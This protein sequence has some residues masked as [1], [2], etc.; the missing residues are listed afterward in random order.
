MRL[1]ADRREWLEAVSRSGVFVLLTYLLFRTLAP[2]VA[3][4]SREIVT[5]NLL[6]MPRLTRNAPS[7]RI[8]FVLD[9]IPTATER[10]W[11][12]SLGASGSAVT[13][14]G[15][16]SPIAISAAPIAAPQEGSTLSAY[17]P[18]VFRLYVRDAISLIDSV[19]PRTDFVSLPVAVTSG[20]ILAV[21]DHDSA[22]VSLNDS[23]I[24]RRVLVLGKAGW[25]TKFVL[26]ALEEANWKTDASILV[27]PNVVVSQGAIASIDTAHYSA[28]VALDESAARRAGE[29]RNFVRSGGGLVIGDAAARSPEFSRLRVSLSA[30]A[31]QLA[32]PDDTV[33]RLSAQF[34]SLHIGPDAVPM[35]LRGNDIAVAAIRFE[36]GRV[37]QIAFSETWRWRM[38]GNSSSVIDHRDWWSGLI[39]GVA[40]AP[41]VHVSNKLDDRAPFADLIAVAGAPTNLPSAAKPF[42]GAMNPVFWII[43]LFSLLLIEWASRRLRGVR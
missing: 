13:W 29:I 23:V 3:D 1:P 11:Q 35:E 25:E 43:A 33:S 27:A 28:I 22:S 19:K 38:Q 20:P 36:F 7:S 12:K 32:E 17:A 37:I 39:S 24:L 2:S 31:A 6:D 26:A 30:P 15:S 18:D 10:A 42:S 34:V 4:G 5:A 14:S 16:L 40:Y 41:R 8:H 9:G 21:A